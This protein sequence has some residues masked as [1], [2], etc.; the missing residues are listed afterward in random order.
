MQLLTYFLP[1]ALG[2]PLVLQTTLGQLM[3]VCYYVCVSVIFAVIQLL[4]YFLPA[5]LG[6]PL[7]LQT[8]L[9][10]LMLV[11]YYPL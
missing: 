6:S 11:C 8:T 1:A 10:Q 3:L 5:A 4:T 2:S 7:V 9:G